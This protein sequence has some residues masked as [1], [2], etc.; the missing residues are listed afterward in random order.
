M[1]ATVQVMQKAMEPQKMAQQMQQFSKVSQEGGGQEGH[2]C[3]CG[4]AGDDQFN[5]KVE[6][7]KQ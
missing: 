7:H 6:C 2:L 5:Q 3:K 1:H 4:C